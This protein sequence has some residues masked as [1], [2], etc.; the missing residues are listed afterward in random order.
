MDIQRRVQENMARQQRLFEELA[1]KG[2]ALPVTTTETP[3]SV[4]WLAL[5]AA[6]LAEQPT[7]EPSEATAVRSAADDAFDKIDT[8]GDGVITRDE[9][10]R[11]MNTSS[12]PRDN[13]STATTPLLPPQSTVVSDGK[14]S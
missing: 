1:K 3:S 11:A 14:F 5:Q 4:R 13:A 8:N 2:L 9:W 12:P 10:V 7:G 6:G